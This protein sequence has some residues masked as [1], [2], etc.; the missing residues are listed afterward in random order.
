MAGTPEIARRNGMLG[1]RPKGSVAKSTLLVQ[2]AKEL[3]IQMY[4]E[5]VRPINQALIDKAIAGDVMAIKEIHD[6]THGKAFQP[7]TGVDGG[8]IQ[9]QAITGMKVLKE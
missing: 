4:Y 9:L 8:P 5:N 3:L 2:K 7:L 1:G 6:R